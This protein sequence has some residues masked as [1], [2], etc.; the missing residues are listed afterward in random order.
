M[1]ENRIEIKKVGYADIEKMYP[2]IFES[3]FDKLDIY[4][5]PSVVYLGFKEGKFAGFISG[6]LHNQTT[7]YLQYAGVIK[8]IRGFATLEVFREALKKIEQEFLYQM[9]VIRNTNVPAI[10]LAM[11]EGFIIMGGR[12]D[13][14]QNYYVELLR[15][16]RYG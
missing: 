6:Y 2:E 16:E 1:A 14:M 9:I 4:Q 8:D 12:Q 10:K 11:A 15:E 7:F 5:L 3:V 13:T